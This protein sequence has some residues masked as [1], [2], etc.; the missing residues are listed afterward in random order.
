VKL[1]RSIYYEYDDKGNESQRK[2][3]VASETGGDARY[4]FTTV[5]YLYNE[6]AELLG[7][8]Y[9]DE[10]GNPSMVKGYASY[11]IERESEYKQIKTFYDESGSPMDISEGYAQVVTTYS[12]RGLTLSESYYNALGE[13]V[14]I[15]EGFAKKVYTYDERNRTSSVSYYDINGEPVNGAYGDAST[16]Y[17]YD[18]YGHIV[19]YTYFDYQ[20]NP[21][22]S[23]YN[24][25]RMEIQYNERS[26]VIQYAYYDTD[27]KLRSEEDQHAF[28]QYEYDARG[29][30]VQITFLDNIR[31]FFARDGYISQST[32]V[33]NRKNDRIEYAAYY[34]DTEGKWRDNAEGYA[35]AVT[36]YKDDGTQESR[37]TYTA[38]E[39]NAGAYD[40]GN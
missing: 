12:Q 32:R 13:P 23:S 20:G 18:Q 1:D 11:R 19:S 30:T 15:A 22:L 6:R 39:M 29:N 16:Y 5:K 40:A 33:Y 27:G 28:T 21:S 4:G 26:Q 37:T 17:E 2:Y 34:F 31:Q 24:A 10:K 25:W 7:E 9:Y 38:V 36:R 35:F 8:A 3:V 14:I